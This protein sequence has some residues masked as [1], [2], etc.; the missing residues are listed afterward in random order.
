MASCSEPN[1]LKEI[2]QDPD[3]PY[4]KP[5]IK[6]GYIHHATGFCQQCLAF[7]CQSC[8]KT[9]T[10]ISATEHHTLLRGPDMPM[11]E[12]VKKKFCDKHEEKLK[13]MYCHN[14]CLLVCSICST[15]SHKRCSVD[16]LSEAC[17][18]IN[19]PNETQKFKDY[20]FELQK[21]SEN[22][23]KTM[24]ENMKDLE[25]QKETILIEA[26]NFRSKV[27][28][29][30]NQS[31]EDFKIKLNTIVSERSSDLTKHIRTTNDI[32]SKADS[33]CKDLQ[34]DHPKGPEEERYFLQF[35]CHI[36]ASRRYSQILAEIQQKLI[37]VE[38]KAKLNPHIGSLIERQTKGLELSECITKV[39]IAGTCTDYKCK[40]RRSLF[41]R[42]S[43]SSLK[44][45]DKR[46]SVV[47]QDVKQGV[48]TKALVLD[49]MLVKT[50]DD[51]RPCNI[52][53]LSA[54][55]GGNLLISDSSNMILK[56]FSPDGCL[57]SS[58]R[59]TRSPKD[60]AAINDSEAVVSINNE[61]IGIIDITNYRQLSLT[62]YID[63]ESTI[64][65]LTMYKNNIIY[66]TYSEPPFLQMIDRKGEVLWTASCDADNIPLFQAPEFIT[67]CSVAGNAKVIVTDREKQT[68][69]ILDPRSG[70][71]ARVCDVGEKE[72]VGITTDDNGSVYVCYKSGDICIWHQDMKE[73]RCIVPSNLSI[74]SPFAVAY[75]KKCNIL[76]ITS[77]SDDEK[78]CN[79]IHRYRLS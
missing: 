13:D 50:E 61:Q 40:K 4:C 60:V 20:V 44:I 11:T 26:E 30:A 56:L 2:Q 65:A 33:I 52:R 55:P 39:K 5:C 63:V 70:E 57:L 6:L 49:S 16:P 32:S 66:S 18:S 67:V 34:L 58:L 1:S 72:P 15:T 45:E 43:R 3:V 48:P 51:T 64:H 78:Y 47:I 23:R 19:L 38:M 9:H 59:L 79:F 74:S 73:E 71:E 10:E 22:M 21:F 68:I 75:S 76:Y 27:I 77:T 7:Y 46:D 24:E 36:E 12:D 14:H 42:D 28:Q 25:K 41:K 29:Y 62:R 17:T 35:Q 31:F 54:I 69:T 53:G 8:L 37:H